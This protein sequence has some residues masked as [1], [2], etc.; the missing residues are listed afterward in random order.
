MRQ[1]Q[2][3]YL[4]QHQVR[5]LAAQDGAGSQDV[6]LDLVVGGLHL[7]AFVIQRGNFGGWRGGRVEQRSHADRRE[8]RRCQPS[9]QLTTVRFVGTFLDDPTVVPPAVLATMS[10]QLGIDTTTDLT[11]YRDGIG[12]SGRAPAAQKPR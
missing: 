4:L 7:P 11:G 3:V 1:H 6:G 5:R 10:R 8:A 9:L 12:R 2:A